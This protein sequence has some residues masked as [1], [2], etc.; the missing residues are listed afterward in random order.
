MIELTIVEFDL[1]H[2]AIARKILVG[3]VERLFQ[4]KTRDEPLLSVPR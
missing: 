2:P 4:D 1:D 3:K